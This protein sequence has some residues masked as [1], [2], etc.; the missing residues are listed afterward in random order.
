LTPPVTAILVAHDSAAVI[1][2]ALA[3]L[4][5]DTAA[6]V[7]D[8]A[9]RDDS[10]AI[11]EAAGAKVIRSAENL[12]FGLANNRGIAAADTP[13]LLFLNPDATLADG[14]VATLLAVAERRPKAALLVPTILKANGQRFEKWRSPICDPVFREQPADGE[15]KDIAFASGAVVLARREAME[16]IGGFDPAIFLYFEDDDLS[17][18]VL[19]RGWRILHVPAA[20]ARHVGNV[21]SPATDRMTEV[22]H[23]HL[24]WSE[25]HV[26]KKHGLPVFSRWRIGECI[27]KLGWA[28]LTGDG[29]EAAKQRGLLRG[30]LAALRGVAAQDVR[31]RIGEG[32]R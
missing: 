24:A 10:A 1:G 16:A 4:P 28:R 27:V 14:C 19:D 15:A 9:S 5:P 21:S 32:T 11:A 6:I 12:G 2:A 18:R 31:D 29:Q 26:R 20:T 22:K 3:S 7:I 17:R 25:R 13:Y 23:W 8:N 30:T